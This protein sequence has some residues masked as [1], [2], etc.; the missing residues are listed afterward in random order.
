[1]TFTA[2]TYQDILRQERRRVAEVNHCHG[3]G[4][5][6]PCTGKSLRRARLKAKT[7]VRPNPLISYWKAPLGAHAHPSYRGILQQLL[8][9]AAQRVVHAGR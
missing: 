7:R 4:Q 8:S 1:M 2:L 5:G 6:H 3:P 9:A